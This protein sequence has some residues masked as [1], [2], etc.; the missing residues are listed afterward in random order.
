VLA[1]VFGFVTGL[2]GT[3]LSASFEQLPAGPIIVLTG[4]AVF[5]ASLLFGVR[6]GAIARL[7]AHRRF[8]RSW[9]ERQLLREIYEALEARHFARPILPRSE[10]AQRRSWSP[11][12]VDAV[13]R[14]AAG[15]G[16]VH[17]AA[18]GAVELTPAGWRRA[19]E[20]TRGERL[21]QAFLQQYPEQAGSAPN[22]ASTSVA[23]FVSP[24]IALDLTDDLRAE[25]RWPDDSAFGAQGSG[26]TP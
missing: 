3:L 4:A 13:L 21:W 2:V 12:Q 24:A 22:L 25:G 20:V 1:G 9:N 8:Q 16:L 11:R 6:R 15:A 5:F 19:V 23:D 10:L 7:L 17:A 26:G 18:S 14:A